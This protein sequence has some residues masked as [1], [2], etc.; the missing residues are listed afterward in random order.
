MK[1]E[2]C[3]ESTCFEFTFCMT[4]LH[5]QKI[6]IIIDILLQIPLR[7]QQCVMMRSKYMINTSKSYIILKIKL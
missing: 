7:M 2:M 5:N 6:N 3:P 1:A 4:M